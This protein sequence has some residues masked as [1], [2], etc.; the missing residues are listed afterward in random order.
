M[1]LLHQIRGYVM[2]T[3]GILTALFGYFTGTVSLGFVWPAGFFGLLLLLGVYDVSQRRHSILRNYPVLGHL[4]FLLESAGPELHQYFVES[5]LSGRPFNR[6]QRTLIY[7]R[8]KDIEGLK[9]FGTELDVYAAGYGFIA[10]SII[11]K[12]IIEDAERK[13]R[14][15]VGGPDCA[16]PYSSSVINISAMSFGALSGNAIRA[17]NTAAKLGG[18]A[19]DTGEG[20]FS[21]HHREP[22]GD[23]IWQIGTG[24]FGCRNDDGSFSID[25]FAEQAAADQIKMIELKISQGAKPGHGG[26]LPAVKVTDEIAD[27]RR[28]PMGQ[29]CFSPPGHSMFSTP[30]GLLEF[31]AAL[32]ERS[33]GKPTGFK[34]CIGN[35]SE[36]FAL[37]KAM[38]ETQITPDFITVD[39]GEG[40][41]GAAP[42][43][44]SN[45]L[46][47]PLVDGLL[48]VHNA[49]VGVNV[50][51]RIK[52][53]ASGKRNGSYDIAAA[54]A[55]GAN[56]VNIARGFMFSVGCIQSQSCHTNTCPVGV[57]TQD[58]RLT[59]ALVVEDKA[60]RAH[61][62][63]RNTVQGL[64]EMTAACGLDHPNDFRPHHLYERG[65]ESKLRRF[66][67]IYDF[68]QPGQLLAGDVSK[69]IKPFW[70]SADAKT[71]SPV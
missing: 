13:L 41:T 30:I 20:G 3:L 63:H 29:D 60:K 24:Y 57:A 19:H 22:G 25:M 16:K 65:S 49:L 26:I 48:L 15:D 11:P 9:P 62:F 44:Y 37:C 35:P 39:G 43:E 66:D 45:H 51:D 42:L 28:V 59:R 53:A 14:I 18:F 46:G 17:L 56:W 58:P 70:E 71:F 38:V 33:G 55:L 1:D 8:S 36:F 47:M 69:H 5:N 54:M 7:E 32:R 10:H 34:I 4:R 52:I 68:Y 61:E 12:P 2:P 23:I 21:R 6:D 40:G 67:Q 50:R 27:A 31:I 64:A